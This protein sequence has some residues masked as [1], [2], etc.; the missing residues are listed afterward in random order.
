MEA[1]ATLVKKK[2]KSY[3]REEKIRVVQFYHD[4]GKNLYQACKKFSLNSKTVLRWIK[5]EPAIRESKKGSKRVKFIR[6]PQH[7]EMEAKLYLE[8]KELRKKGLKV[9][10]WWFKL[11]AR[12]LLQEEDP[13]NTFAFSEC[14]FTAFKKRNRISNRRATNTCQKEPED[15]RSALQRFHR[16]IR[17]KAKE[18]DALGPLG[19]W[20]LSTVANVDQRL[21]FPLHLQ[22]GLRMRIPVI[23]QFGYA[24][25]HRVWTSVSVL[26]N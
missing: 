22:R 20:T 15:K 11:R 21:H 2:R 26:H 8:Y 4:N 23:K 3:T 16:E 12:Q 19:K 6:K 14:W 10:A 9:K 24:V 18:G 13:N 17:R 25:E 5:D 1:A 7:P